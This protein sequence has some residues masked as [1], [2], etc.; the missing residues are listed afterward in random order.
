MSWSTDGRLRGFDLARYPGFS[1]TSEYCAGEFPLPTRPITGTGAQSTSKTA[2]I[3]QS[4]Q[5]EEVFPDIGKLRREL[6][7][8]QKER[9]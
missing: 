9:D 5:T 3:I 6:D 4:Q 7:K 1:N 8:A 2:S